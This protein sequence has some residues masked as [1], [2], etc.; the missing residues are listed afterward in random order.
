M[1]GPLPT[2]VPP[3]R[4]ALALAVAL[5]SWFV[6]LGAA[7]AVV[8]APSVAAAEQA[9]ARA[10]HWHDQLELVRA[11]GV[12][13]NEA[14]LSRAELE[15]RFRAERE[16]THT[17]LEAAASD[18]AEDRRAVDLMREVLAGELAIE[19]APAAAAPSAP[20]C[21]GDLVAQ[22]GG[23]DDPA[24]LSEL[25]YDCY[26]RAAMA[27]PFEGETL[28]RLSVLA[29]LRTESDRDRRRR[30]FEALLPLGRLVHGERGA[31]SGPAIRQPSAYAELVRR[32]SLRWRRDG[33]PIDRQL[34]ALGLDP[35]EFEATLVRFLERWRALQPAAPIEPWDLHFAHAE[36]SRLL[37]PAVPPEALEAISKRFYADLGADPDALGV[38]LDLAPRAGKTPV[39][40]CNFGERRRLEDGVERPTVPWI[41]AT[42]RARGFDNLVE[43]LHEL[44]HA[45]HIAAIDTRPAFLDWPDLDAF[46]E[47]LG[48]FVA[49]EAYEPAWQ[50][51]YLG[52]S[53]P[54]AAALVSKY[55]SIAL[56]VCWAL[57]EIRLHRDPALDPNALWSELAHR[58]LG[59]VPHPEWPWWMLRGQLVSNPGYMANYAI[60]A[61]IA[62]DLRRRSRERR[63]PFH[64]G[65][66]G[67]YPFLVESIYRFGRERSSRDVIE[68]YL[69]RRLSAEAILADLERG[70]PSAGSGS[71]AERAAQ[72]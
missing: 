20:D 49:L 60:G 69:G 6:S 13:A 52:R 9:F 46:S 7:A 42:Y 10:R 67:W 34:A 51:R 29:R 36:A 54:L 18:D 26:G 64:A 25:L 5:L 72:H 24:P 1:R 55:G 58:Y 16:A 61:V 12:E 57:F 45:V 65:G 50:E 31:P 37:A 48:D 43:L 40:F 2:I 44:G 3:C 4:G 17:L 11:R 32:G 22:A 63:G 47:A 19:S 21:A 66:V 53:V 70:A 68:G 71:G 39:A 15:R 38:R 33:S 59:V 28:D 14:G 35:A 8:V 27:L 56:D 41:F 30:L 23:G 62:A